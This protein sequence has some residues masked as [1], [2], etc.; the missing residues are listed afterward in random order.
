MVLRRVE[1]MSCAKV[2]G[3]LYALMGF[4]VG[5]CFTAFSMLGTSALGD[6]AALLGPLFGVGAIIIL[7]IL[8]GVLG[9]I[10]MGIAGALYNAAAKVAGGI[11]F[12]AE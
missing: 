3:V 8:Y 11:E 2:G 6:S 10:F 12:Q 1:P 4:L 5:L 9:L 7:P